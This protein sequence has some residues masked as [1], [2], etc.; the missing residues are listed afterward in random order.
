VDITVNLAGSTNQL[1]KF[2]I[3]VTPI[4]VKIIIVFIF[5]A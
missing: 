5:I 1:Q 2:D 4:Y 3:M